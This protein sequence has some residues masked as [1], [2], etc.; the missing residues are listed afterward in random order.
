MQN[1]D[2][3]TKTRDAVEQPIK[4][5]LHITKK[6]REGHIYIAKCSFFKEIFNN[7]QVRLI[8]KAFVYNQKSHFCMLGQYILRFQKCTGFLLL[9]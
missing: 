2:H 3:E 4:I 6:C 9:K 7:L 5:L 1:Q 8:Y